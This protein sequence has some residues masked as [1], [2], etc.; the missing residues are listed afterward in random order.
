M[1]IR[2]LVFTL[3]LL[4]VPIGLA[5]QPAS[6]S[7][8]VGP[9]IITGTTCPGPGSASG[10]VALNVSGLGGVGISVQGNTGTVSF[11]SSVDA[12]NWT[13]LLAYPTSSTTGVTSTTGNG[14][15]NAGVGGMTVVRARLSQTGVATVTLRS[16]PTTARATI[17]GGGGGGSGT[18]TEV[19]T[20]APITGGPITVSG[21]VGCATC[22]T[23]AAALTA[24]LPMIGAGSQASAVGTRSGNTTEFATVSGAL[25]SGNCLK[26]D[27]SGNV[28]DNGSACGSGG[29]GTVT[30]VS[31]TGGLISVATPTSTPALTVAGTSGG[32]PYFSGAATWA[33][34]AALTAN[35]PVIGG[36]AGTAPSVGSRSGNTTTFATTTGTLTSGNCAKFDGS[37]NVVDQGSACNAYDLATMVTGAPTASQVV[38]HVIADRA[39]TL[40]VTNSRCDAVTAATAQTDFVIKVNTVTKGTL[41]FAA[42]G[43]TCSVVSPTSTAISAGD[44]ITLTAPGSPDATLADLA[45]SLIGTNP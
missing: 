18:V 38:L 9:T 20:S 34:S 43:T 28:V 6:S 44:V 21:T 23:S 14:N 1:R 25:T 36:G 5:A 45:F 35:A 40:P 32:I 2:S 19:D 33:S 30:S 31:F 41:R 42:S 37:G 13:A 4:T 17:G 7:Q 29:A 11:E 27:A 16:A 39:F 3:V 22:V 10:C 26:S 24:N 12:I 8:Q 15:W